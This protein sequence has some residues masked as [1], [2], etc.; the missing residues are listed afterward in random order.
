MDGLNLVAKEAPLVNERDGVVV[1]S[2]NAGAHEELGEWVVPVDPLDVA[3]QAAALEEA[4]ALGEDE[5]R[6]PA[7]GD[8]EHVREHDARGTGSRR[9]WPTSTARVRIRR[10]MSDLSHVDESGAVRMVDV[11]GKPLSR[12]RAVARRRCGWRRRP[13]NGSA[14]CRRATR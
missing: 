5:R 1:L 9:S 12:R 4:L 2:V 13:R 11:G 14:L 3:G 6:A 10:P 8:R 7:G